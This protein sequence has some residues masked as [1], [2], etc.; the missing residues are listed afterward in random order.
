MVLS[1]KINFKVGGKTGNKVKE[2]TGN[3]HRIEVYPQMT[4]MKSSMS[5]S[6]LNVCESK[7]LDISGVMRLLASDNSIITKAAGVG[8]IRHE[9]HMNE[10][11]G[12]NYHCGTSDF[13]TVSSKRICMNNGIVF[14]VKDYVSLKVMVGNGT[15]NGLYKLSIYSYH[16]DTTSTKVWS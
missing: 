11:S 3:I 14:E 2:I 5:L 6:V 7:D 12:F 4:R 1:Y 9:I 10:T 16:I 13:Y 8:T 15:Y